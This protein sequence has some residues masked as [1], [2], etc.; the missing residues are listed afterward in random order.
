VVDGVD[1][2][3]DLDPLGHVV[4]DEA[5]ALIADVG[6][7]LDR[8]GLEVVE[9]DHAVPA[10]EQPVAEVGAEETCTSGDKG[11]T[12]PATQDTES[13]FTLSGR[14]HFSEAL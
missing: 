13:G 6:D 5:E 8:R 10:R 1:R 12:H 11:G 7:V 2:L 9:A 4:G 3:V 14:T